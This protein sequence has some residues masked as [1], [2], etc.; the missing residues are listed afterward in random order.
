MKNHVFNLERVRKGI[1]QNL[2]LISGVMIPTGVELTLSSLV[3]LFMCGPIYFINILIS[4]FFYIR[5]TKKI[6]KKRKLYV[7]DVNTQDKKSNFLINECL[8]N[9]YNVKNFNSEDY[10][11]SKYTGI[12]NSRIKSALMS[13]MYLANLNFSQKVVTTIGLTTNLLLGAFG[14]AHGTLSPGDLVFLNILMAQ[15]FGPLFNLGNVYRGWQESF[16]E[17]NEL[18]ELLNLKSNIKESPNATAFVYQNGTIR[19]DNIDFSFE[20][21]ESVK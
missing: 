19:F 11:L 9:Y 21:E 15:I 1:Q 12:S 14:V 5:V 17:I 13:N 8:S 2:Q 16:I 3:V 18:L 4:V 10:E 7:Q 20:N 6:S